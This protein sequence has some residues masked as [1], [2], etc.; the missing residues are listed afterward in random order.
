MVVPEVQEV[1]TRLVHARDEAFRRWRGS[2]SPRES[3]V[4][5][6]WD[7]D[8]AEDEGLGDHMEKAILVLQGIMVLGIGALVLFIRNY[9]PTYAAEKGRNLATKE[10][11]AKITDEVERVKHGYTEIKSQI[12]RKHQLRMAALDK[13]LEVHQQAYWEWVKLLRTVYEPKEVFAAAAVAQEWWMQNCL[14]L[15]PEV[16]AAFRAAYMVAT[17]H[18]RLVNDHGSVA[19]V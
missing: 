7:E 11:I 10:D 15:E 6:L 5:G 13:R 14:Y 1:P 16:R 4:S 8:Y 18:H 2:T 9:L 12:D 3:A 17:D 19:L